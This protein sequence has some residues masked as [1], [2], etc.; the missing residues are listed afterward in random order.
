MDP[1]VVLIV[2]GAAFLVL[3]LILAVTVLRRRPAEPEAEEVAA[4]PSPVLVEPTPLIEEAEAPAIEEEVL[5]EEAEEAPPSVEP[6][7][8]IIEV[9]EVQEA[10]AVE[11]PALF[12]EAPEAPP[13]PPPVP[14][15]AIARL[16]RGLAKSRRFLADRLGL[17]AG[18]ERLDEEA[19]EEVED[20]LIRADVGVDSAVAIVKRLRDRTFAPSELSRELQREIVATLQGDDRSLRYAQ[21]GPTAWLVVGVNGTGKT[22]SIAKLAHRLRAEGRSVVLAAADTFRAAAIDQL[23]TWAERVGVHMV[24]HAAG[25]DPG[26]VIFDA[27]EHARARGIDVV[28]ADTAGRLHT[29]SNLME[30]LKKIGRVAERQVGEIPEVLLVMD[31]TVGQNGIAQARTFREAVDVT[32]VVLTKLD[33]SARGGVVIAVEEQLGIPVKLV[34]VGEGL[35]DLEEF[36]PAA[37]AEALVG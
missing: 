33:G 11:E 27:L 9:P 26:A 10:P 7:P 1:L 25:A 23:G 36:D 17:L 13:A 6:V 14:E 20:A 8:E 30:E 24:R 29:K 32:G 3:T 35:D 15:T 28:I 12:V 34:G 37:F 31:A 5:E 19:W 16:S 4:E 22:T 21:E 2:G 18:R